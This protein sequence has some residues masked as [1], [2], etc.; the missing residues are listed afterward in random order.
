MRLALS[1]C[2]AVFLLASSAHAQEPC[3]DSIHAEVVADTVKVFHDGA[4]Y[5]CCAVIEFESQ[6][7]DTTI[8][9]VETETFPK[10]Q[11]FCMCCFN[12]RV[13]VS[14]V[15]DGAYWVY[16]W[17]HD[18]SVLYGKVR[19][20]VGVPAIGPPR[21]S[22]VWQSDCLT[23]VKGTLPESHVARSVLGAPTPNPATESARI[24]YQLEKSGTVSVSVYD[25]TG[26]LVSVLVQGSQPA[27]KHSLTW[28]LSKSGGGRLAS[29]VYF[30]RF[31]SSSNVEVKKLVIAR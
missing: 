8:S 23:P 11:C 7:A 17:N 3:T 4:Y 31:A 1:V 29:G 24:S 30:V 19:V 25:P 6:T 14:D 27:G 28:N 2:F 10:G 20:V 5:N 15:P 16:V 26:S 21:I 18:K 12:L 22:S 9:I 13:Y